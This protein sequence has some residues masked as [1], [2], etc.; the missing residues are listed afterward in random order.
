M[1]LGLLNK[2]KARRCEPLEL[3][4]HRNGTFGDIYYYLNNK[5]KNYE[6]LNKLTIFILFYKSPSK[7]CCKCRLI[8]CT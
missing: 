4:R 6:K 7:A 8:E 5:T 1:V 2:K 3:R